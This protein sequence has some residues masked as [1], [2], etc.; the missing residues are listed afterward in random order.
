MQIEALHSAQRHK[1]AIVLFLST[2]AHDYH[3][4]S[5]TLEEKGITAD[6]E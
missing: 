2:D 3:I 4:H 5:T 6:T 1:R